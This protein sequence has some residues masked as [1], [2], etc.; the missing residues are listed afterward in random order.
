MRYYIDEK[1]SIWRRNYFDTDDIE[2]LTE[3]VKNANT[4]ADI[5]F[6]EYGFEA[7]ELLYDTEAL[8]YK[9]DNGGCH[10]LELFDEENELITMNCK[11]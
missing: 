3:E 11:V 5:D 4:A 10:T 9:T 8:L 2:K 6:D 7:S 1:I